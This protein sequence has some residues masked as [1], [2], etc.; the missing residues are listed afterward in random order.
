[1]LITKEQIQMS[2]TKEEIIAQVGVNTKAI[3]SIKYKIEDINAL[4]HWCKCL[5]E[6][7][8]KLRKEI[9]DAK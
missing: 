8:N 9:K 5:E 3:K 1:M 7:V 4:W 2:K 6:E